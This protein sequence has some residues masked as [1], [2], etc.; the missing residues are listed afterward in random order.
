MSENFL[1]KNY[2]KIKMKLIFNLFLIF[3]YQNLKSLFMFP[4]FLLLVVMI[5]PLPLPPLP[6]ILPLSPLLLPL[7]LLLMCHGG[8]VCL[9][10]NCGLD[11]WS[12]IPNRVETTY[13]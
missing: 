2:T 10:T 5:V 9:V 11:G 3:P 13:F 8:L 7:L 4:F 1:P 6:L 12:I